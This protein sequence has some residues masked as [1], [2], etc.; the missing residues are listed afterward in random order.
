MHL[1]CRRYIGGAQ[2]PL[3]RKA[4]I[5]GTAHVQDHNHRRRNDCAYFLGVDRCSRNHR[6]G[7]RRANTVFPKVGA[8]SHKR[9]KTKDRLD[10]SK[11]C[12][13][14]KG[15]NQQIKVIRGRDLP[16]SAK[17][18]GPCHH[19][20]ALNFLFLAF[21]SV[22]LSMCRTPAMQVCMYILYVHV[23]KQLRRSQKGLT[24]EQERK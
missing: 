15:P 7:F 8:S 5:L 24:S 6:K 16:C 3:V 19:F 1:R 12:R 13:L 18:P 21:L 4:V 14:K 17:Y 9:E 2:P 20:L 23:G 10:P 11:D 22:M